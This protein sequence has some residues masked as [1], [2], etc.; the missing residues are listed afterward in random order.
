MVKLIRTG[1]DPKSQERMKAFRELFLSKHYVRKSQKTP[2]RHRSFESGSSC[3]KT[4][5]NVQRDIDAITGSRNEKAKSKKN[6]ERI[7]I[8]SN[9][10][11]NLASVCVKGNRWAD[12]I[13][14]W[15]HTL[16]A[17]EKTAELFYLISLW[18]CQRLQTSLSDFL[19]MTQHVLEGVVLKWE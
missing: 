19:I 9:R 3:Y 16:D 11:A 4:T 14:L 2:S 5:N 10:F 13:L 15:N 7:P 18:I 6:S 8:L 1:S 12:S 17:R